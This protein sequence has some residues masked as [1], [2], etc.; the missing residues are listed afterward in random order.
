M[1]IL[2][3]DADADAVVDVDMNVHL[4]VASW[5]KERFAIAI[6]RMMCRDNVIGCESKA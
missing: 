6:H 4:K 2:D 3:M 5:R 1:W